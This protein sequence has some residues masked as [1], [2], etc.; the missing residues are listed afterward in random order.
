[1]HNDIVLVHIVIALG[2]I[3]L[4]A[5]AADDKQ[6]SDEMQSTTAPTGSSAMWL[7][8]LVMAVGMAVGCARSPGIPAGAAGAD[9]TVRSQRLIEGD[10]LSA[11][12]Q[13]EADYAPWQS[14]NERMFSFN[15]DV[16]DGWLIKPSAEGGSKI[17][18][19][20]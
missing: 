6:R 13:D 3:A 18:P 17:S 16:L 2:V 12:L 9:G 15:H 20:I 11:A 7:I 14:F 10:P 5:R 1:M 4:A 19:R 8:A